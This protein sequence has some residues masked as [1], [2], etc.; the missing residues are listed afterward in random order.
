M[1]IRD[2]DGYNRRMA[3]LFLVRHPLA[4]RR[5][6][7]SYGEHYGL[8]Q[9]GIEEAQAVGRHLLEITG[10]APIS[11]ERATSLRSKQAAEIIAGTAGIATPI[12]AQKGFNR[13]GYT[14]EEIEQRMQE[15]LALPREENGVYVAVMSRA[16]IVGCIGPILGLTQAEIIGAEETDRSTIR[17]GS[18]TSLTVR[19]GAEQP[20]LH[21]YG[22]LPAVVSTIPA[23]VKY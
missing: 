21:Y 17:T 5:L 1:R 14:P 6:S 3:E 20:F 11:F 2:V 7:D 15:W 23:H 4:H 10:V 18:V 9:E 16:A 22:I 12:T 13:T 8:T 19:A